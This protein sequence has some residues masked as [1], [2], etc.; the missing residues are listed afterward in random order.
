MSCCKLYLFTPLVSPPLGLR[1]AKQLLPQLEKKFQSGQDLH[2]LL[3]TLLDC[4]I[5]IAKVEATIDATGEK[6]SIRS[7]AP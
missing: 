4:S 6:I 5:K 3:Q 1:L 7:E 2:E